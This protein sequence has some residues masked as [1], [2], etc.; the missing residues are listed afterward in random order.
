MSVHTADW[1]LTHG[2]VVTMDASNRVIPD[3]AVAIRGDRIAAVGT[4]ADL[5]QHVATAQTMD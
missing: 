5:E 2:V 4:T 1:L 3:G